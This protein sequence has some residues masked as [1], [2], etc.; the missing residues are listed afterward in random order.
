[1]HR[2]KAN[3]FKNS[4]GWKHTVI[5]DVQMLSRSAMY[6]PEAARLNSTSFCYNIHNE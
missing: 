4:V 2:D 3:I 1:M 6:K 5:H